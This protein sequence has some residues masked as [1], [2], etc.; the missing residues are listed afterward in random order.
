[1]AIT[2]VTEAPPGLSL[3][4]GV[5]DLLCALALRDVV[6]TIRP[7]PVQ[8]LA[9]ASDILLGVSVIRGLA[10]PV[11]DTARLLGA[12]V[13]RPCRFVTTRTE[14]YATGPVIGVLPV[15]PDSSRL[16]PAMLAAAA[17][18]LVVAVGVLDS[19]PLLFLRGDGLMAAASDGA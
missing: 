12:R 9:G 2:A 15:E 5:G 7:L 17:T 18:H 11:V 4:F 14:A 3:V 6:E 13:E 8:P 19:R 10:V 1:V 16:P